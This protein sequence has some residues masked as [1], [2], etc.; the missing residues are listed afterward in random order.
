[1]TTTVRFY[2]RSVK[3]MNSKMKKI[4]EPG[5]LAIGEPVG[6][7]HR[8]LKLDCRSH[9]G[10]TPLG[11]PFAICQFDNRMTVTYFLLRPIGFRSVRRS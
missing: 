9:R 6:V 10:L 5:A 2:A 3:S 8:C 11:S 4:D 7:S 1:M